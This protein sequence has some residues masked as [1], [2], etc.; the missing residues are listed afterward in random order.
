MSGLLGGLLGTALDHFFVGGF[1]GVRYGVASG[2]ARVQNAAGSALARMKV[3]AATEADDAVTK[4]QLDA[5]IP[6]G[7][8]VFKRILVTG[9]ATKTS[10]SQIPA[11]SRIMGYSWDVT[12]A[13]AGGAAN[14]VDIGVT[15]ATSS[16]ASGLD[17]SDTSYDYQGQYLDID[18]GGSAV[19]VVV[20]VPGDVT[21]GEGTLIVEYSNGAPLS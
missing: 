9:G 20:T 3:A 11:N 5:V 21:S 2:V 1:G 15:G 4:A 8:S 7:Q 16:V 17:S 14:T 13:F 6:S 12:T 10:A 18:V 19:N